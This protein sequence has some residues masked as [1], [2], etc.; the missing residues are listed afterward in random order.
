MR[1][2][3]QS[4][5]MSSMSGMRDNQSLIA[6]LNQQIASEKKLLAPKDDPIATEKILQLSN[7]VA[8]RQQFTA[9]Q[10]RAELALNYELTVIE[11][12]RKAIDDAGALFNISPSHD[13]ALRDTHAQQLTG[14]FNHIL[15]LLNTRDPSGNYIFSGFNTD[16]QPYAKTLDG[17]ATAA[18]YSGTANPGGTREIEIDEGRLVQVNDNLDAVFQAGTANDFLQQLDTAIADLPT[19]GITQAQITAY[20]NLM[21]S[22]SDSLELIE[23]R[24]T[25]VLTEIEDTRATTSAL[26]LQEKNA[27]SD[28]ELLDKTE[29]ILQLQARTTALEATQSA[30]ARTANLSLFNY[31]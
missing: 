19:A 25:G 3:S 13:S 16:T 4:F 1:I 31:L 28:I 20:Q 26:L 8:T 21:I 30:Y 27:L 29:A 17:G 18:T 11:E 14:L 15:G 24:I 2:D 12:M 22:T 5:L 7:R 9:N 23:H 6:R 10:D